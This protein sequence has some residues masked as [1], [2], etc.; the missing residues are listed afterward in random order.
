MRDELYKIIEDG[1]NLGAEYIEVRAEKVFRTSI[2]T[3]DGKVE[4][5]RQGIDYGAAV[6]VLVNGAWGFSTTSSLNLKELSEAAR[7]AL[8]LIHI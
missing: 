2:T 5:A 1:K 6:R 7:K 4:A 3:K 8:S